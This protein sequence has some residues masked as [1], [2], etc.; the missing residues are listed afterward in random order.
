VPVRTLRLRREGLHVNDP[1]SIIVP[2]R[3]AESSLSAQI[4]R[5]LEV[6]PDLT[7]QFEIVVVDDASTDHTVELARD[8]AC[9]YPQLRLI[10]HR[11]AQGAEAAIQTGMQWAQSRTVFVIEDASIPSPADL[12]RLWSLREDQQLVMAR[13]DARPG[14]LSPG[15]LDRLTTWGQQL[16]NL[17]QNE[18]GGGIQMIR[19]DGAELIAAHHQPEAAVAAARELATSDRARQ[20]ASHPTAR[21]RQSAS[22]LR[23]LRNLALGE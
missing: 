14:V 9:Q 12:R 6:L 16:K 2:V 5:L 1:L 15:L 3:N 17:A 7:G 11:E 8:L 10:R 19:R 18:N 13:A 22:F 4:A 21:P 23:H 20:D